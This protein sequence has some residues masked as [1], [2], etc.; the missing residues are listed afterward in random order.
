LSACGARDEVLND[1]PVELLLEN[2]FVLVGEHGHEGVGANLVLRSREQQVPQVKVDPL[3]RVKLVQVVVLHDLGQQFV[4]EL[5]NRCYGHVLR[6]LAEVKDQ[7]GE[8]HVQYL[9]AR[10]DD[11]QV[12]HQLLL[13]LHAALAALKHP[14]HLQAVG[15]FKHGLLLR[16]EHVLFLLEPVR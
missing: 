3:R 4:S 1:V 11:A 10:L 7:L 15:H 13:F 5:A 16:C 9:D 12:P 2:G 6:Q 14:V 8:R